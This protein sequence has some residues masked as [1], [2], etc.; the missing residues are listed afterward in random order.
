MPCDDQDGSVFQRCFTNWT[1]KLGWTYN[2]VDVDEG[3]FDDG[4]NPLLCGW[5]RGPKCDH[6]HARC[7]WEL[8]IDWC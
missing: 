4:L 2:K 1:F 3:V 5:G 7:A 8:E 6:Q